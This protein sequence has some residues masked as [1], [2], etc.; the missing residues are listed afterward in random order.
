MLTW[1]KL[2]ESKLPTNTAAVHKVKNSVEHS[3]V[4]SPRVE[5]GAPSQ[6]TIDDHAD[7][8]TLV[9]WPERKVMSK[10]NNDGEVLDLC[11]FLKRSGGQHLSF[12][13]A[14]SS[15]AWP[16]RRFETLV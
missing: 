6:N 12:W 8:E 7:L 3:N 4:H 10:T 11:C 9:C 5:N 16:S 14:Y 15:R 13:H 2:G 1:A